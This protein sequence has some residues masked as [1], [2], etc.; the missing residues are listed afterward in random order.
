MTRTLFDPE[1]N[2][3][4]AARAAARTRRGDHYVPYVYSGDL[5]PTIQAAQVAERPLL[6]RGDPGS[7]KST[8]ARDVALTLGHRYYEQTVTSRMQARDLLYQFDAVR[9]L[10][11]T[12]AERASGEWRYV[13]PGR[14]WW[15]F[16]PES[17]RWRGGPEVEIGLVDPTWGG[18]SG[19]GAVLLVDEIDKAD[20]DVPNDLLIALGE[21]RFHV[22]ELDREIVRR[23]EREVL[24]FVTTNDERDLPQAFLRR[25]IVLNLE[26]PRDAA[27][28]AIVRRHYP[29]A[30]EATVARI[31]EEFARLAKLAG[32]RGARRPGTAELLDDRAPGHGLEARLAPQAG[33]VTGRAEIGLGDLIRVVDA[34]APGDVAMA[35]RFARIL[36]IGADDAEPEADAL[37]DA[38]PWYGAMSEPIA[39]APPVVTEPLAGPAVAAAPERSAEA[40]AA[41]R[42]DHAWTRRPRRAGK[43]PAYDRAGILPGPA[44]APAAP[45]PE[46]LAP[47]LSLFQPRWTR[48]LLA[49]AMA[50]R[51][52][53][54]D[55]DLDRLI[56]ALAYR[57]SLRELPRR[58]RQTMRLG[59]H[60]LV[61][62]GDAMLPFRRDVA[63]ILQRIQRIGGDITT[64]SFRGDPERVYR[65]SP[66]QLVPHVAPRAGTPVVVI[67][68]LGVGDPA[69]TTAGRW[70]AWA[71]R[72]QRKACPVVIITP[73]AR[74]DWPAA[75]ARVATIIPWDRATTSSAVH[76]ARRRAG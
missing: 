76:R 49:S 51:Q 30:S 41:P 58:P 67:G 42:E 38:R 17:A 12:P 52:R 70:L 63:Q 8:L 60:V 40:G 35:R 72:L 68:D 27:L 44:S 50:T 7:G 59:A 18:G 56:D 34:L 55:V 31:M 39:P 14:L 64:L 13:T 24:V 6:L 26:P 28:L 47:A 3:A 11:D 2:A 9:R 29:D 36:Q 65:R 20:P 69:V 16:D 5:V 19:P 57:A 54:G 37:D 25:C 46:L 15:A 53:D 75:L 10:G 48:S 74:G 66:R 23:P 32:D 22:D 4:R 71:Q 43:S 45:P 33:R 73:M 62:R 61:E 1:T 21:G